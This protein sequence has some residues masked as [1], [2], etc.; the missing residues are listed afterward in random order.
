MSKKIRVKRTRKKKVR[1]RILFFILIPIVIAFLGVGVYAAYLYNKADNVLSDS[2]VEDER[3]KSPLRDAVVNPDI[4]NVSV[5]IMG[6]DENEHRDNADGARTDALMVA[7]F[8]KDD[9]SIN[10]LSIPRDSLVYIP[11]VGYEDKINH[12]HAFGG[13]RAT[14]ET[15]EQLLDIPID[16]W[17]RLNF[18][19]FVDVVDALNGI[20]VEVPYEFSESD[21]MDKRDTIHL[22]E[23]I[24][25]LNGEEAL[26][27]ARTRKLDNDIQRGK[28]QQDIMKAIIDRATSVDSVLNYDDVLEAVGD[29]MATNMSFSDMRTFISYGTS[30]SN[31]DVETFTLGGT[32]YQPAGIYYWQ[33]DPVALDETKTLLQ[34]HLEVAPALAD[35]AQDQSDGAVTEGV[36]ETY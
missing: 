32:D 7:T 24:Q 8:N 6:V 3:D 20:T 13:P 2:Y 29:N 9:A 35:E 19:A 5:L 34:D 21:S 11:H 10:I 31:L 22:Q 28:R 27:L 15:V 25:R 16:Y 36:S 12:A 1:R 33:I 30:G 17:V 23:G 26:A 4:D 18:H 14:V